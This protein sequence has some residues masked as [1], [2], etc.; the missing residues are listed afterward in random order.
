LPLICRVGDTAKDIGNAPHH[1]CRQIRFG[2]VEIGPDHELAHLG[3]DPARE[4][5]RGR[6]PEAR[7]F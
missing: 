5:A 2:L 7:P 4:V 1:R 6:Q 3:D